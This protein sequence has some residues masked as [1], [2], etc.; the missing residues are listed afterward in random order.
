[1]N[2]TPPDTVMVTVM[3]TA[4]VTVTA[5]PSSTAK[6]TEDH[7]TMLTLTTG[8]RKTGLVLG[9]GLRS[10]TGTSTT[11]ITSFHVRTSDSS[12]TEGSMITIPLS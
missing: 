10:M 3:V 8:W 2:H 1:M 9:P 5:T 7:T 6:N 12:R 11:P 4:M